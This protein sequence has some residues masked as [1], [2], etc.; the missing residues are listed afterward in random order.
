MMGK[1]VCADVKKDGKG[2]L[3]CV[4]IRGSEC[5]NMYLSINE[6]ILQQKISTD[7]GHYGETLHIAFSPTYPTLLANP[8]QNPQP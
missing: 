6:T 1:N 2:I 7:F 4:Y 8:H 5:R 3:P